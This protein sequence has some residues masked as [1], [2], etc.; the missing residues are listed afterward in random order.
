[1]LAVMGAKRP[2]NAVSAQLTPEDRFNW[3]LQ[4]GEGYGSIVP[5]IVEPVTRTKRIVST[6]FADRRIV[7]TRIASSCVIP[8]SRATMMTSPYAVSRPA[9]S[10]KRM[11][12]ERPVSTLRY[13]PVHSPA[14][15]LTSDAA[16]LTGT[17][18]GFSAQ[19]AVS[20]NAPTHTDLIMSSWPGE[21]S[22]PRTRRV[23]VTADQLR[24]RSPD[25]CRA[26]P[27]T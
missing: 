12:P 2:F 22:L 14:S 5:V 6:W 23:L 4:S 27:Y 3:Q 13:S 8:L 15:A 1:M 10:V 19:A 24:Q 18:A 16:P 17:G 25:S 21:I 11:L 7:A 20:A 9:W 26:I